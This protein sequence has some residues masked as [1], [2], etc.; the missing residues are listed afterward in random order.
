MLSGAA[1]QTEKHLIEALKMESVPC[2]HQ[3]LGNVYQHLDKAV[4]SLATRL[5]LRKGEK[6]VGRAD[7]QFEVGIFV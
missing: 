5:Y 1:N 7:E 2:L 6:G 3:A 4:L